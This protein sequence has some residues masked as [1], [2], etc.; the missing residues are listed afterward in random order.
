MTKKTKKTTK[1]LFSSWLNKQTLHDISRITDGCQTFIGLISLH[2]LFPATVFCYGLFYATWQPVYRCS[3]NTCCQRLNKN[4]PYHHVYQDKCVAGYILLP[5]MILAE[6]GKCH[7]CFKGLFWSPHLAFENIEH[8]WM[9]PDAF[10][11]RSYRNME[12]S[13]ILSSILLLQPY[14]DMEQEIQSIFV[15]NW[16]YYTAQERKSDQLLEKTLQSHDA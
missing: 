10:S 14:S 8:G 13:F 16:L 3:I 15:L 11:N 12:N 2:N 7:L 6:H 9:D 5:E 1:K 4:F